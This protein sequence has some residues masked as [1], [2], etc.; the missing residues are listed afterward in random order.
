MELMEQA[1]EY[2][3]VIV[4]SG[5]GGGMAA[6]ILAKA[7]AKVALM[8]AGG[9]YDPADPKYVTQ[10]KWP[11]ESPRRGASSPLRHF[12]DYD[13]AWGGWEL[14]GEPY[15]Q[16]M[17][18]D[19]IGFVPVCSVDEQTTGDAFRCVSAPTILKRRA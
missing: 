3:V 5:A 9:Y 12:G 11:W 6:Y 18:L 14:E 10:L 7:G 19:S 16:K 15:T 8:E 1:K 17:A 13:A 4:G 2:D